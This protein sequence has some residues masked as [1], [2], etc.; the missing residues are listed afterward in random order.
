MF[1]NVV[2]VS[3]HTNITYTEFDKRL[4][5]KVKTSK[6]STIQLPKRWHIKITVLSIDHIV[7]VSKM[8]YLMVNDDDY[9]H[10]A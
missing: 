7:V 2:F 6:L 3:I 8:L 9:L 10:V 1:D 5:K 4:A